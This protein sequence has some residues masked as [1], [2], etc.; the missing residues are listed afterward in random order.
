MKS[1][2]ALLLDSLK[3]TP[4]K[5]WNLVQGLS[6]ADLRSRPDET[7]FSVLENICHLRDLEIE[8]YAVR[9]TR[10]LNEETP[11]LADFDG[12]RIAAERDYNRESLEQALAS[13]RQARAANVALLSDLDEIRMLRKG[14]LEGVG[15][16]TLQKLLLL[17]SEHDEGHLEELAAI[18]RPARKGAGEQ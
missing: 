7:A 9:I 11:A 5:I 6:D 1:S 8:G 17:M 3:Q 14:V 18:C 4:E 16:I 13:F 10:I 2:D 15:T 12:A